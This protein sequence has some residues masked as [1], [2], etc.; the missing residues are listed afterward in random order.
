MNFVTRKTCEYAARW[1]YP[2]HCALFSAA[3]HRETRMDS[4]HCWT[5][6]FRHAIFRNR[7]KLERNHAVIALLRDEFH[8]IGIERLLPL[9]IEVLLAA[10]EQRIKDV[11]VRTFSSQIRLGR[12]SVPVVGLRVNFSRS[13]NA[14]DGGTIGRKILDTR[15]RD[16]LDYDRRRWS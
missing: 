1:R 12:P 6:R 2:F 11:T 10:R 4:F 9:F 15:A 14:G 8:G 3:N 5:A 7:V 16:S 13:R